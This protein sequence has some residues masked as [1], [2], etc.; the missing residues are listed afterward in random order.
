M[1]ILQCRDCAYKNIM[2]DASAMFPQGF[3]PMRE[4]ALPD[5]SGLAPI[6][7]R[8]DVPVRYYYIDFGIS[9]RF[10]TNQGPTL[11]L[12]TQGLDDEVPELSDTIPYDPFKTDIFIVGNLFRQQF[13]QVRCLTP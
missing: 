5:V 6:L 7:H 13:L 10:A 2:M 12:G 3:H 9:T 8:V 1:L 11:V 4:L